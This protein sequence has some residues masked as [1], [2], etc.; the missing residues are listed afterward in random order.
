[1]NK[2]FRTYDVRGIVPQ[3]INEAVAYRVGIALARHFKTNKIC[4][5]HDARS[6]SLLLKKYLCMGLNKEGVTV[7]DIGMTSTPMSYFAAQFY[8]SVIVTASHNPKEY[9][10]FKINARGPTGVGMG[11]GLEK[12]A[13]IYESLSDIDLP[14]RPKAIKSKP[15]PIHDDFCT[16]LANKVHL[17]RPLMVVADMSNGV[18]G[19]TIKKLA[20]LCGFQL[21]CVNDTPDGAFPG[22]GPNPLAEGATKQAAALVRKHGAHLGVIFDSDADRVVFIDEKGVMLPPEWSGTLVGLHQLR[23]A[24][25]NGTI[26]H[27]CTA[28]WVIDKVILDH[29]GVSEESAVGRTIFLQSMIQHDALFG[30]EV[31]SHFY[32]REYWYEDSGELMMLMMLE[33]LSQT[34]KSLSTLTKALPAIHKWNDNVPTERA[35]EM[36]LAIEKHYHTGNKS[37]LDGIKVVFPEFWVA[38]RPSN[39]E[40]LVRVFVEASSDKLLALKLK[41]FKAVIKPF[42]LG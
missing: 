5:G 16:F 31:S 40:P 19:A 21:I 8:P 17:E 22:H 7:L 35:K 18:A 24:G 6:H 38:A 23:R 13:Q 37:K 42:I 33:L 11:N 10:G 20:P 39:T 27:D 26:V 3:E 1:M 12:I 30:M 2:I 36:I 25:G 28:S 34:S 4:I 9:N 29:A 15:F 32:F 41:E 14:D